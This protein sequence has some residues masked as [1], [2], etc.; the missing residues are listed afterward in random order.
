MLVLYYFLN[1]RVFHKASNINCYLLN[2]GEIGEGAHYHDIRL[3]DTVVI[4]DSTIRGGLEDWIE[5]E[6]TG[7]LVPKSVRL[8]DSILMHPERLFSSSEFEVRQR[9]LDR[10]RAE[11]LEQYGGLHKDIRTVFQ[12]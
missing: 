6:A 8:V 10:Q 11:R 3:E 5:S 1:L 12:K 4:L 7:L 2:T 9:E